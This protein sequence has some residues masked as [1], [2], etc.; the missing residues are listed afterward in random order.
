MIK[1]KNEDNLSEC[2]NA[3]FYDKYSAI[4]NVRLNYTLYS[5]LKSKFDSS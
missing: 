4:L 2:V 3:V 1:E 5:I